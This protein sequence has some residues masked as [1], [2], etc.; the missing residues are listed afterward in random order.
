MLALPLPGRAMEREAATPTTNW[1]GTTKT[2]LGAFPDRLLADA[3]ATFFDTDN[4]ALLGWAGLASV[5]MN[6]GRRR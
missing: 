3:K 6:N 2:D 1:L 4:L 5:A